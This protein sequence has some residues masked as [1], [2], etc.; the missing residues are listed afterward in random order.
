MSRSSRIPG[1]YKQPVESRRRLVAESVD[2]DT[3]ELNRVLAAGGLDVTTADK[4]VENVVGTYSLPFSIG[5]NVRVNGRDHLVPMVVEEP[6]VVAAASNAA[7]MIREGGG[8]TAR[9]D[10]PI[11]ISQI[12][13]WD[14]A[15][16]VAARARLDAE[17]A[18]LLAMADAAVETLVAR[19]GGARGLEVRDLG[20][21]LMVV[22]VLVD[23]RD[24]MGA[25]LVNTV[26]EKLAPTVAA[27]AGG[28]VGLRI[29]SNLCDR[30]CVYVSC[31]VPPAMLATDSMHGE[32]VRDGVVLASRFAERDPYRAAT[33]NKGIMNGVDAVVM[34]T[35]NDWRAVEAGAHAF[36]ARNG[37]YA[38][39]ATW[40]TDDEGM[41][42]GTMA[43]P[44]ALG[45]V[46]GTLRV[47]PGARLALKI[48]G[49]STAQELATVAAAVGLASNLA[50]LRAL[51]TEG[52][53]RGHMALH[54]RSVAVAVGARG[55][56]IERVAA[57][58]AEACNVTV[59]A[60]RAALVRL[61]GTAEASV[62][63]T[64]K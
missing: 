19:G 43:L 57:E 42:V 59:D 46:G 39:L 5:L 54:A 12:Q 48:M 29:L 13:L 49:V 62:A 64:V 55:D 10:D 53:Q 3:S 35:G 20:D 60:A 38:P 22:H 1:F 2:L 14:V 27:I 21:G 52:I 58:I 24:A 6:S 63:P 51:A 50:A 47:H 18:T 15:D 34:A 26:A 33:H 30:R 23:V 28:T 7:R 17:R 9:H 40:H 25:N 61:R 45:I 44:L 37:A 56:E 11:M 8:F 41:L 31:R 16:P 4:T 32:A 36:A